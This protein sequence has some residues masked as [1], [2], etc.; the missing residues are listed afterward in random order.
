MLPLE[1]LVNVWLLSFHVCGLYI[2]I[3]WVCMYVR[4]NETFSVQLMF[5]PSC[6]ADI[7]VI[8]IVLCDKS[9]KQIAQQDHVMFMFYL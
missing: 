6:T 8:P 3:V 5:F 7:I 9:V 2:A 4:M 1:L